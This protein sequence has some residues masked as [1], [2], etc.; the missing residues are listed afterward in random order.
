MSFSGFDQRSQEQLSFRREVGQKEEEYD[1]KETDDKN[2][3]FLILVRDLGLNNKNQK[4]FR[5][6]DLFFEARRGDV[7]PYVNFLLKS[8]AD[9]GKK[10]PEAITVLEKLLEQ[11]FES[12]AHKWWRLA[13]PGVKNPSYSKDYC[14]DRA[15]SF[16][17]KAGAT[18]KE[19]CG[20][21]E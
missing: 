20:S 13:R 4:Y 11:G 19:I 15:R 14:L 21:E 1:E 17:E 10:I 9:G 7:G 16:A 8:I 3:D 2:P 6:R 5:I 18:L 12:E